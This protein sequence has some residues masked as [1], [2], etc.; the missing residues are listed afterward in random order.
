MNIENQKFEE[1]RNEQIAALVRMGYQDAAKAFRDLGSVQW[2]GWWA[3]WQASRESLVIELPGKMPNEAAGE[4][5]DIW[6]NRAVDECGE[7]IV[8]VGLK[9]RP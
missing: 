2:A 3:G 8:A 1:W 9:V 5:A 6:F 4:Q 7:A